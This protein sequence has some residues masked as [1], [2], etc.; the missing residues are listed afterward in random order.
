[1]RTHVPNLRHLEW[2]DE[3]VR[4]ETLMTTTPVMG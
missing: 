4:I 3:H 1:M 2:F